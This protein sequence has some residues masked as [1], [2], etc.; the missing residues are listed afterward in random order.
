MFLR[1]N[2]YL[3][4]KSLPNSCLCVDKGINLIGNKRKKTRNKNN[5]TKK[6]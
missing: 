3:S 2:T 6:N 4:N 1:S 5:N